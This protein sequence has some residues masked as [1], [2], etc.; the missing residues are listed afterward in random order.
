MILRP[1]LAMGTYLWLANHGHWVLAALAVGVVFLTTLAPLHDAMHRSLDLPAGLNSLVLTVLGGLIL[2]S[3]HTLRSTHLEHH[4]RYPA[5]DDPEAWLESSPA[6]K[7]LLAGPTYR[8]NLACW[9]WHHRPNLR[10]F[11]AIEAAWSLGVIAFAVA[12]GWRLP[13]V[14]FYVLLSVLGSWLFPLASV[15]GVH[16]PGESQPLQQARTLRGRVIPRVLLGQT[17]HLEHHLYP[18]VPSY[19]LGDLAR[20]LDHELEDAGVVIPRV[21]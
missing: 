4:R 15:I 3:G 14:G 1:F 2:E 6:W 9:T 16:R 21:L 19:R 11:V 7:V 18:M 13:V 17:Y 8:H 12:A 10:P 5:T 20:R